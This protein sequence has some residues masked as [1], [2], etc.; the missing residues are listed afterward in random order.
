MQHRLLLLALA[1]L[2]IFLSAQEGLY[3]RAAVHLHGRPVHELAAVGIDLTHGEWAAGQQFSSDFSEAEIQQLRQAGFEVEILI[4]DVQA[5]YVS[6]SREAIAFRSPESDS[7]DFLGTQRYPYATPKRFELGS[8]AGFFTYQEMLEHLDAM[9]AE[10][11]H[12]ISARQPIEGFLSHEGRP[13]YWMRLSNNPNVDEAKPEVL[14]TALHHAR[15]PNSLSQ[16]IFFMWYMLE[17]YA[18]DPEVKALV[19]GLE[20]YFLPCLNPDGYIYN[21]TIAPEGGGLWRK[22]RRDNGN[23]SFG[24]DLNR[25]YDYEWAAGPGSSSNPN[26]QVYHGPEAFSEPETQAVRAFCNQHQFRLA[27][28]YHTF[29]NLLVYPWGFS[30]EVCP[31][32]FTFSTLAGLMTAQND[33]LA[34]TPTQ[35]VG[36]LVNGGSDD[37]MYGEMDEKPGIFSFT[38]EVGQGGFW[39]A[40]SDIETNCKA[41][42]LMNLGAARA[43]LDY[44]ELKRSDARYVA[45]HDSRLDYSL[46]RY[47][48]DGG[49]FQ[50]SLTPLSENVSVEN[51]QR[52]YTLGLGETSTGSFLI[53][54]A[55]DVAEGEEAILLLELAGTNWQRRDTIWRTYYTGGEPGFY[56]PANSLD[57]WDALAGNW[58]LTTKHFFSAPTAFTDSPDGNYIV[59]S[60]N[61]LTLAEPLLMPESGEAL[62]AFKARWDIAPGADYAQLSLSVNGGPSFPVCG[63]YTQR[64][65]YTADDWVPAYMGRQPFWVEE[66]IDLSQY[67]GP[68]DE[69]QLQFAM[70]SGGGEADGFY[71]DDLAL[72]TEGMVS[73]TLSPQHFTAMTVYPNPARERFTVELQRPGGFDTDTRLEVYNSLGQLVATRAIPVGVGPAR[74]DLDASSWQAG[75]YVLHLAG[76]GRALVR[77]LAV[78]RK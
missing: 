40:I 36:Y 11:P 60:E 69:I 33:Y 58:G 76:A 19:D 13:I 48:L 7:C 53:R 51:P 64:L 25:N 62:L 24:V 77:R 2:P 8:M 18:T 23:G 3:S 45:Q 10:Y 72:V 12:L 44:A 74:L 66:Q 55:E 52:I 37:W 46:T 47:G 71:F 75:L 70:V 68:G 14:Y 5:F 29:G 59:L 22:N 4:E 6:R 30:G 65:Y 1:V 42:M 35:T 57:N 54:L 32:D 43:A 20:L 17:N 61:I 27:L 9:A 56:D 49:A 39:P 78:V 21:E 50:L 38:P 67:A 28:N 63:N 26:S 34:G 31:D 16:L 73:A 15:E 41:S